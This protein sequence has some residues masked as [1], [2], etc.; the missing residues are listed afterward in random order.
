MDEIRT[1]A[2][3]LDEADL[4]GSL[5]LDELYEMG[6]LL[7]TIIDRLGA[8]AS[9][10]LTRDVKA[11]RDEPVYDDSQVD[12]TFASNG[13]VEPQDRLTHALEHLDGLRTCFM[14][15]YRHADDYHTA[16]GHIGL[17]SES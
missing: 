12:E 16:M 6:D 17:R 7:K 9:Y 3:A 14:T 5:S 11:L 2:A 10:R 1:A 8:A 13:A 4:Y 15:A